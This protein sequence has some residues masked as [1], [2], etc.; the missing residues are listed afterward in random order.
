MIATTNLTNKKSKEVE[1]AGGGL[2]AGWFISKMIE[3]G[4]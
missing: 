2:H 1:G 4:V 3:V